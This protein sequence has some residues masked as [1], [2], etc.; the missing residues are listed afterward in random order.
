VAHPQIAA[1]ARVA[2]GNAPPERRIAGQKTLLSRAMH[3]IR[4]DAVHDEFLVSNPFAQAIL[5]F[6]GGANGEEAPVRTIQ[7][8]LT[9]LNNPDRVGVDPIHNEI[10]VPAGDSVLVF[11]RE[12]TGNVAPIRIIKGPDTKLTKAAPFDAGLVAI[13]PLRDLLVV[14]TKPDYRE[15]GFSYMLIYN[16]SANG[17]AKPL[18]IIGGP[19]SYTARIMQIQVYP[20]K[21]WI[22]AA[23][24]GPAGQ[25][26]KGFYVGVW[27]I[28]DNGDVQPRWRIGEGP[29]SEMKKP[30]GVSF[31]AK[32]KEIFVTDMRLNAVLTYYFPEIF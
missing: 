30:I 13:D 28:N 26:P 21:G 5:V 9:Q 8:P 4:Y 7:G 14:S 32:H 18:R 2:K 19:K 22:V 1:F 12:A 27:S 15:S 10:F 24:P 16:R 31:D 17:N 20:A 29:K 6:R 3:D 23:Q 25:E 11:P